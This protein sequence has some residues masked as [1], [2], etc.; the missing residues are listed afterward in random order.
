M[1]VTVGGS[2]AIDLACRGLINPGDGIVY[3][4]LTYLTHR[5]L[6]F[7]RDSVPVK[8]PSERLY[9]TAGKY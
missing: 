8:L 7:W 1:I 2:E 5:Q 9:F 6:S 3:G 4:C